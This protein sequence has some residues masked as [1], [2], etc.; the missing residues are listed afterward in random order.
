MKYK[1]FSGVSTNPL[2]ALMLIAGI[3]LVIYG[4]TYGVPF[5]FDG[6][7]QIENKEKIRDI[8]N[9][10]SLKGFKSQRPLVEF[11]F[12]VNYH[13]GKLNPFGFHLVNILI[14]LTNGIL[15]YFLALTVFGRLSFLQDKQCEPLVASKYHPTRKNRSGKSTLSTEKLR[16]E[17]FSSIP[18]LLST[19]WA[20]GCFYNDS[21]PPD[22]GGSCGHVVTGC[23]A[24]A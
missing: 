22:A 9:Y 23:I 13:L 1:F 12:A 18:P 14:H 20:Q 3:T 8:N 15:V 11:S 21:C 17:P 7:V 10:M 4:N 19:T 6:K 2:V 16:G 24:T 5:V